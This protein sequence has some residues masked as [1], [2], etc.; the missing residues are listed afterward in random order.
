MSDPIVSRP[1]DDTT[2]VEPTEAAAS[3]IEGRGPWQL[4]WRRLTRDKV[5]IGPWW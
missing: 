3:T 4:A 5:A 2:T 1:D